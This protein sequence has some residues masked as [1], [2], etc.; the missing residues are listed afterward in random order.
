MAILIK[1]ALRLLGSVSEAKDSAKWL[2]ESLE[3]GVSKDDCLGGCCREYLLVRLFV[4]GSA[5]GLGARCARRF[6]PGFSV[7]LL[8]VQGRGLL[9][10]WDAVWHDCCRASYV[11]GQL[12][13]PGIAE[14]LCC[15]ADRSVE[16]VR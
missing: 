13:R 2:R 10:I 5:N 6:W 12:V 1:S 14:R 9:T 4:C 8:Q 11:S 7:L 16:G 15:G 3:S